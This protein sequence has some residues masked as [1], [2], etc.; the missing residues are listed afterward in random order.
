MTDSKTDIVAGWT[1]YR[2]FRKTFH[3]RHRRRDVGQTIVQKTC[4]L[5]VNRS[6]RISLVVILQLCRTNMT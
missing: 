5:V 1:G 2:L 4:Y 3:R 6:T